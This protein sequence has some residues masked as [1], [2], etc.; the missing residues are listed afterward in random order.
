[1]VQGQ[2][3]PLKLKPALMWAVLAGVLHACSFS[4][5]ATGQ[6]LGA[7][8]VLALSVLAGLWW[9]CTAWQ[10]A[11][12][13]GWTF[14]TAHG[15]ATTWW[16][17]VSMHQHGGLSAPLAALAVMALQAALGLYL[18]LALACAAWLCGARTSGWVKAAA[19]AGAWLLAE[20]ARAQWFTGFPWGSAGYAHVDSALAVLAPYVGVYGIGAV[21]ALLAMG[22]AWAWRQRSALTRSGAMVMVLALLLALS[23]A[24][25]A[26]D[27]TQPATTVPL[28]LLQGNVPQDQ[29]YNAQRESALNWYVEQARAAPAGLTLA[30]EIAI[31]YPTAS[32]SDDVWQALRPQTTDRALMLGAPWQS[33]GVLANS[34]LAWTGTEAL[35]QRNGYRYDKHHL[36]PFG[37]FIPPGFAWFVHAMNI[38]MGEFARGDLPQP[39]WRWGGLNWAPNICYEDLFGE[40]L[41]RALTGEQPA[42]VLVNFSNI[43]WFGDTV[44]QTQHLNI[45]RMRTLEL[46]RP[47]VRI[48]NTGTTA[49]IDHQGRVLSRLPT[50]TRDVL[51]TQVTGREGPPTPYAR[52][53][54]SWG[55]WP[56]WVI[57]LC[58]LLCV[59]VLPPSPSGR[60]LG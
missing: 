40:E 46:Q 51:H 42:N 12:A 60:G 26:P 28:T 55:L 35:T 31:V 53:V 1:M 34:V 56:L 11:L 41:A 5:P 24:W 16:L 44:A 58:L 8:Q 9:R 50:W 29:K 39:T 14:A 4:W 13:L 48:T 32:W 47:M 30:P 18:A 2:T 37:E 19:F 27:S 7:V 54:S 17:Y 25:R 6:A 23:S 21:T 38:P 43:A 22:V 57:G 36:V 49:V 15:V 45:S 3:D 33:A 52:W 20:L 59:R 10:P